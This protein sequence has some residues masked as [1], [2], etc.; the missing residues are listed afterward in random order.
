MSSSFFFARLRLRSRVGGRRPSFS[1]WDLPI[2][3]LF[4][5]L[6]S[7]PQGLSSEEAAA[8]LKADGY[9]RLL[10]P[11]RDKGFL[12]FLAQ[13]KSPLILL[14]LFAALFS[15]VAGG[16]S[17]AGIIFAIVFASALLSFFKE[18][19]AIKVLEKLLAVVAVKEAVW[20]DGIET[21]V[22]VEEI[23]VGDVLTLRAGD[24]VPAD[25]ILLDTEGLFID[26]AALT[27]EGFPVSK[28]CDGVLNQPL[29]KRPNVLFM[30]TNVIAGRCRA[31]VV[32]TGR[33]ANLASSPIGSALLRRKQLSKRALRSS[34]I[35]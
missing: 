27:G 11:T 20:R 13:F 16:H 18:R 31:L 14:L 28:C 1:E 9:N 34:A 6:A 33:R 17:D 4:K 8:K 19:S 29:L 15:V 5:K 12:L 22:P 30:S 25:C 10:P 32:E 21:Q 2:D 35:F 3:A 26:E 23:V 24:V 7:R